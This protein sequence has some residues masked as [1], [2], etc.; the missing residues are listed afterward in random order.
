METRAPKLA[1]AGRIVG[2]L[3]LLVCILSWI[4]VDEDI[5]SSEKRNMIIYSLI[6]I[7]CISFIVSFFASR[8]R[9]IPELGSKPSVE[10]QFAALESTP[11]SFK[12]SSTTTDQF[13]FETINSQTR[14]IIESIVGTQIEPDRVEVQS[15]FE[16]LSKGE[17]G[18]FS[19]AQ[20]SAN[21]APH[22]NATQVFES[23]ISNENN[24][25]TEKRTIIENIPLP[26]QQKISTPDLSWMEEEQQFIT[27][28][29]VKEVPIPK[30]LEKKTQISEKENTITPN[31]PDID[32]LL[33]PDLQIENIELE[34][35]KLPGSDSK[36]PELPDIDNLF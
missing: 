26:N 28:L 22:R 16:S 8:D 12:S 7:S 35:I 20:A 33:N 34:S 1:I 32:D 14:N 11:S 10:E 31:L 9:E 4:L 27:E 13:G 5:L 30:N 18:E 6:G 2:F 24:K 36:T 29:S 17:I 21:P 25:A 3:L 19:S 15:A 23:V